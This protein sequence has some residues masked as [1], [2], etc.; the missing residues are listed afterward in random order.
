[1]EL[2][3]RIRGFHIGLVIVLE[4]ETRRGILFK[5]FLLSHKIGGRCE[6]S[7]IRVINLEQKN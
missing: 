5:D 1:M 7:D 4:G 6:S 2:V 3:T